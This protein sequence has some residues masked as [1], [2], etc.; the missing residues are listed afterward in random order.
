MRR[1][2]IHVGACSAKASGR[3]AV[4]AISANR[5]LSPYTAA[6]TG[7]S[8]QRTSAK[9]AEIASSSVNA[10]WNSSACSGSS[11]ATNASSTP[12][13]FSPTTVIVVV[14]TIPYRPIAVG[15]SSRVTI[16][17]W[18]RTTR[19]T[20]ASATALIAVPRTIR[21]RSS[22]RAS[23]GRSAAGGSGGAGAATSIGAGQAYGRW[24]SVGRSG[25]MGAMETPGGTTDAAA[26]AAPALPPS[27][28]DQARRTSMAAERTWLAWWR[29]ALGASAGALGVGRLAPEVLH[30]APWPY[31]LLG[32]GYAALAVG[33]L[34]I[35]AQRQ[36]ELEHA[37]RTGG[38]MPLRFRTVSVFTAG[39]IAL[40]VMTVVL[41]IAQT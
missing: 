5:R 13:R 31:I 36:R 2:K 17:P 39:G 25:T 34:L 11:W 10:R 32:C 27:E 40:A 19:S 1:K 3:Y 6:T 23:G 9:H 33:L 35:G 15:P 38:H 14:V 41:V 26:T 22:P 12:T 37:L 24:K 29:S 18:A 30:V 21:R 28:L 8:A 7:A 4:A 20:A 16:R